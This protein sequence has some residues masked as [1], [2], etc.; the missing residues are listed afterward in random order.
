MNLQVTPERAQQLKVY[1][2]EHKKKLYQIIEEALS[3]YM[4]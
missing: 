3:R 2:A 4:D 1:A